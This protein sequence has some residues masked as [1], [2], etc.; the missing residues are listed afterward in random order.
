MKKITAW[1]ALFCL[2]SFSIYGSSIVKNLDSFD[3]VILS[4]N[5]SAMLVEGSEE[6]I[7]IRNDEDRLEFEVEGKSLKVKAKD[8][9]KYNKTPTIK[10]I[11]T[12]RTLRSLRAR[13]GASAYSDSPINGDKLEL[14][15][16]SGAQ[17]EIA[18][19]Q[20]SLEVSVSEGG[21]L[22]LS[23]ETD[24]QE[25]KVSTGGTISAYKLDCQNAIA[26]ATTGGSAKLIAYESIDANANTGGSITYKGDPKKVRAKDGFSGTIKGW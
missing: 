14:R 11:I 22:K 17:G 1:S 18:I 6:A 25:L 20:E 7:E 5:V 9:I 15:F 19:D 2:F 24:W 8:L 4:G 26:K 21:N 10:V 23:G 13:A 16:S 3:E 12:Y